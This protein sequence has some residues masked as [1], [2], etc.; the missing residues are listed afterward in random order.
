[1]FTEGERVHIGE[2]TGTVKTVYRD[3]WGIE[4]AL[5]IELDEVPFVSAGC[6]VT[7]DLDLCDVR[8]LRLS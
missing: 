6:F 2:R 4:H 7:A 1:M 8:L 3:V 5:V